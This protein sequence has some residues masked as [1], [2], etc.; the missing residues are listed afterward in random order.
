MLDNNKKVDGEKK[1]RGSAYLVSVQKR[2]FSP[3][4]SLLSKFY[5]R[6]ITYMHPKGT[7]C[8]A[9]TV[10]FIERLELKE[11]FSFLHGHY[12]SVPG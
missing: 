12:F 7:S 11:K 5:P 8:G 3:N 6:N 10:K 4:S 1:A 2:P 9:P